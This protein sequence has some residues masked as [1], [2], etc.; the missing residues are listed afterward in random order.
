MSLKRRNKEQDPQPGTLSEKKKSLHCT[1]VQKIQCR[2][3]T[4]ALT[5]TAEYGLRKYQS[6]CKKC[7]FYFIKCSLF[8]CLFLAQQLASGPGPPHSRG[9]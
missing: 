2:G 5:E 1:T 7:K 8:V 3:L 6:K 9:F 4:V